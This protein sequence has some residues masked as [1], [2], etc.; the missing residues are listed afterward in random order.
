[1]EGAG[2]LA[3]A[4]DLGLEL[5]EGGEGEVAA[6]AVPE[7]DA[8]PPAIEVASPLQ[9][10]HL[11]QE[12]AARKLKAADEAKGRKKSKAHGVEGKLDK[13]LKDSFPA[14]DASSPAQPGK[15]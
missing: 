8:H 7:R 4:R 5:V 9:Q 3:V 11:E 13:A 15:K 14:S 1:M 10:M 6:Q 2:L 12:A